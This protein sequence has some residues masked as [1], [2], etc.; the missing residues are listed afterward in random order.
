MEDTKIFKPI[1]EN[2]NRVSQYQSLLSIVKDTGALENDFFEKCAI[3]DKITKSALIKYLFNWYPITE[4]F[5]INGLLY[6]HNV[7]KYLKKNIES[8]EFKNIESFFCDVLE[9]SKGEFEIIRI[10][11]NNFHPK[12]FTRLAPKLSVNVE[13]LISRN[14]NLNPATII[15]EKNIIS[16]FAFENILC[17]FANFFVVETIAYNIVE[18]M[19]NTFGKLKN[20][21]GTLLYNENEMLYIKEHLKLE[22]THGKEVTEMLSK[23]QLNNKNFNL[24]SIYVEELSLNFFKFWEAL[25]KP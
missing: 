22:I 15:L 8:P 11:P 18:S 5:A 3:N 25:N 24:L 1:S 10:A 6:A 20:P 12:A 7:A 2:H 21:R 19:D 13:D 17:G 16:N 23:L 4:S 14:Y 9:I